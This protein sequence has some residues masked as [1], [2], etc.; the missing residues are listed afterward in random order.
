MAI[1]GKSLPEVVEFGVAI[2]PDQ[3]KDKSIRARFRDVNPPLG[4]RCGVHGL[5]WLILTDRQHVVLADGFC[6]D[7]LE[8][9]LRLRADSSQ[10]GDGGAEKEQQTRRLGECRHVDFRVVAVVARPDHG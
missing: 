4:S 3:I 9:E 2:D 8:Q 6:L 7:D 10:E 5:T 1:D